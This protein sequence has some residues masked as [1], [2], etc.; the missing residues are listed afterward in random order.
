MEYSEMNPRPRLAKI[1]GHARYEGKLSKQ[2]LIKK[3][4][5][6]LEGNIEAGKKPAAKR[7]FFK[8][9]NAVQPLLDVL[10]Y[11]RSLYVLCSDEY[12]FATEAIGDWELWNRIKDNCAPLRNKYLQEWDKEREIRVM[13]E[14]YKTLSKSIRKGDTKSSQWLLTHLTK[15]KGKDQKKDRKDKVNDAIDKVMVDIESSYSQLN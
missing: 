2:E 12:D 8:N 3:V 13:S 1:N 15:V 9:G 4:K 11:W 7:I 14:A 5:E 10:Y 6:S